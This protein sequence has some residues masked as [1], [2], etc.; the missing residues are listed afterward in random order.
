MSIEQ[1]NAFLQRRARILKKH[2]ALDPEWQA[3]Q[4]ERR[5][6]ALRVLFSV[7][8]ALG[9]LG[10]AAKGLLLAYHGPDGYAQI[11]APL[12]Q[13][14]PADGIFAQIV[15]PDPATG[16]LA[17]L[18]APYVGVARPMDMAQPASEDAAPADSS[19]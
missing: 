5:P 10:F 1:K 9:V 18:I 15:A 19:D 3:F 6:G 13:D 16:L 8:I 2:A 14:Q 11:T 4:R 12:V 7:V 17:D